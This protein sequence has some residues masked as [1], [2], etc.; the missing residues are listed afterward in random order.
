MNYLDVKAKLETLLTKKKIVLTALVMLLIVFMYA[1][2]VLSLMLSTG[3]DGLDFI[4]TLVFTLIGIV[5]SNIVYFCILKH[6][7]EEH[8]GMSEVTYSM[9]HLMIQMIL[10]IAYTMIRF[11]IDTLLGIF[12]IMLPFIYLPLNLCLIVLYLAAECAIAYCIYDE[13]INVLEILRGVFRF[14]KEKWRILLRCGLPYLASYLLYI[15]C[16]VSVISGSLQMDGEML[17]IMKTIEYIAS[18]PLSGTVLSILGLTVVF[19]IIFAY[20]ELKIFLSAAVLYN[21]NKP[22][23]FSRIKV[24][25]VK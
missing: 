11:A 16:L 6:A 18:D 5:L 12:G 10:G 24:R 19:W 3:N 9:T 17:D 23:Y 20:F 25:N 7:R 2:R 13:G 22:L 14:V 15:V 8:F 21:E 1:A 4:T